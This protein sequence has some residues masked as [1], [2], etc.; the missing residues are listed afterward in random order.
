[1]GNTKGVW[2]RIQVFLCLFWAAFGLCFGLR[3]QYPSALYRSIKSPMLAE[4]DSRTPVYY[5]PA[6]LGMS[7]LMGSFDRSVRGY[8]SLFQL[9]ILDLLT[10]VKF[11]G[12]FTI[13][14]RP[15][16]E[17]AIGNR[18]AELIVG[19]S[20]PFTGINVSSRSQVYQALG[21]AYGTQL[22]RDV[23]PVLDATGR[24]PPGLSR[25]DIEGNREWQD[26]KNRL[27]G[28]SRTLLVNTSRILGEIGVGYLKEQPFF[29]SQAYLRVLDAEFL[30]GEHVS[31]GFGINGRT[32][33]HVRDDVSDLRLDTRNLNLPQ[34]SLD[35]I[36]LP[37]ARIWG[38]DPAN[39]GTQLLAGLVLAT[40]RYYVDLES[41]LSEET[42][43]SLVL[44]QMFAQDF[45][46]LYYVIEP[47]L[48]LSAGFP[49]AS[50]LYW[51]MRF[52]LQLLLG[53]DNLMIPQRVLDL[54]NPTRLAEY[55]LLPTNYQLGLHAGFDTSL[56]FWP[57]DWLGFSIMFTDL[58][59]LA[60]GEENASADSWGDFYYPLDLQLGTFL[61][62]PLGSSFRLGLGFD[63][64]SVFSMILRR[65]QR[66][67]LVKSFEL[68]DHMRAKLTFEYIDQFRVMLHYWQRGIGLALQLDFLAFHPSVGVEIDF[69]I[70]D[71]RISLDILRFTN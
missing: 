14:D 62:F 38:A 1:M 10:S 42:L 11:L 46:S 53:M 9:R 68:V 4:P 45:I 29:N 65:S 71:M 39:A 21:T 19:L 41:S 55:M 37:E 43:G 3:A 60:P 23:F 13:T 7:R 36:S 16:F 15:N 44:K 59:G 12:A 47:N 58:L 32:R 54:S 31:L 40:T 48:R 63:V 35:G 61:T 17:E 6:F 57:F 69:D 67:D 64:D 33:I 2:A 66:F 56:L 25:A 49:L 24:A 28:D 20:V 50:R 34:L 52:H 70:Q 18:V 22:S 27:E 51:G 26:Y 30:L 8:L 5:N